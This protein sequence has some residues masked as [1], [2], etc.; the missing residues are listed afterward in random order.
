MD[1]LSV[2]ITVISALEQQANAAREQPEASKQSFVLVAVF[3]IVTYV[4][5]FFLLELNS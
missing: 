3:N 2:D 5:F 4:I 1:L